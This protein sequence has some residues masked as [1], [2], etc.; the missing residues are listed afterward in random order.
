[1]RT[2][3]MISILAVLMMLSVCIVIP[4]S[5]AGTVSYAESRYYVNGLYTGK[6]TFSDD[7]SLNIDKATIYDEVEYQNWLETGIATPVG[8]FVRDDTLPNGT[9]GVVTNS[10]SFAAIS[11]KTSKI[12]IETLSRTEISVVS[13]T[14]LKDS[15]AHISFSMNACTGHV[16]MIVCKS[17]CANVVRL[18]G[19]DSVLSDSSMAKQILYRN[20]DVATNPVSEVDVN[21]TETGVYSV[22]VGVNEDQVS[23]YSVTISGAADFTDSNAISFAVIILAVLMLAVLLYIS[24]KKIL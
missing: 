8:E 9:F 6:F 24:N 14:G 15:S 12:I 20:V 2:K 21:F 10:N 23:G 7:M 1:M 17:T 16:R 19:I 22:V 11:L 18:S 5:D 3:V 13:F 4:S